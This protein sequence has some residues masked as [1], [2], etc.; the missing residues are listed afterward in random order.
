MLPSDKP[1]LNTASTS[2]NNNNNINDNDNNNIYENNNSKE[3][4]TESFIYVE[5]ECYSNFDDDFFSLEDYSFADSIFGTT[6]TGIYLSPVMN[7]CASPVPTFLI[8]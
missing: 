3:K 8:P 2:I 7:N 5:V 1:N 4:C 6:H